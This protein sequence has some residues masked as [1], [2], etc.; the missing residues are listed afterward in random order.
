MST[1]NLW[2]RFLSKYNYKGSVFTI[3]YRTSYFRGVLTL[4]ANG[5]RHVSLGRGYTM[6]EIP[7]PDPACE[8]HITQVYELRKNVRHNYNS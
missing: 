7:E 5:K 4:T 8:E 2:T 3:F 6:Y 1:N